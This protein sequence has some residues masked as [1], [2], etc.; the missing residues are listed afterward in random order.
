MPENVRPF[1]TETWKA[2]GWTDGWS[3]VEPYTVN[4]SSFVMLLKAAGYGGDGN[5]VHIHELL[6][7]GALGRKRHAY[8]WTQGWSVAQVFNAQNGPRLLLLKSS[9]YD[10]AGNNVHVHDVAGDGAIAAAPRFQDRWT[11]GWT[12]AR[13]YGAI[14]QRFLFLMKAVGYGSDGNNVHIHSLDADGDVGPQLFGKRWTAM[15][16]DARFYERGGQTFVVLLKAVG[17]SSTGHNLHIDAVAAN[18]DILG[19]AIDSHLV[20]YGFT[21][22]CTFDAGAHTYLLL[23]SSSS[24]AVVVHH[25]RDDG[26]LGNQVHAWD[27]KASYTNAY[28]SGSMSPDGPTPWTTGWSDIEAETVDGVTY[29]FAI[30]RELTGNQEKRAKILRVAPMVSIGPMVIPSTGRN[31]TFQMTLV[32][33][34]ANYQA[35]ANGVA[36][37]LQKL[38]ANDYYT[39][40]SD[41]LP[42]VPPAAEVTY[43]IRQGAAI[44]PGG[45]FHAAAARRSGPFSIALAS[46]AN[47]SHCP[48]DQRA[49]NFL[50]AQNPQLLVLMGDTVYANTTL[51]SM[52]WAEH[53]QQRGVDSYADAVRQIPTIATWDDHDFGPNNSGGGNVELDYRDESALAFREL[54]HGLPFARPNG[55]IYYKLSWQDVDLFVLDVRYF[56]QRYATW[57]PF[58]PL[59]QMLGA[60]QWTWLEDE[61]RRSDATFKIIVSGT[62]LDSGETETWADSYALEWRRLKDL[63][64]N[65]KGVVVASGDIHRCD[66]QAHSLGG[67][68]TLWEIISS[69][70]GTGNDSH[71]FVIVDVDASPK[72]PTL[73]ARLFTKDGVER[74]GERRVIPLS[75]T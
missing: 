51:R 48:R 59:R 54:F 20:R 12:T 68:R 13:V 52:I 3:V 49:W 29:L 5:N 38:N 27:R 75:A 57:I 24:G 40:A 14:N 36:R 61:V 71:G 7:G 47:L 64:R 1:L 26:F 63:A 11:E 41:P 66:T 2:E 23:M 74:I 21:G 37:G 43:E 58:A 70:I 44:I 18:G 6:P 62:T 4:G 22:A 72:D 67:D 33:D 19:P 39:V 56:R 17:V 10:S 60:E 50:R 55:A 15:W 9:G 31:F 53:L 45:T 28:D 34:N 30:K 35:V 65:H 32:G 42:Q 46:C 73:T 69:G 16:T 8:R 25:L